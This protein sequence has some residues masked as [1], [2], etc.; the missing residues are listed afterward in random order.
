M[1]AHTRMCTSARACV[2]TC[3]CCSR[4]PT[5]NGALAQQSSHHPETRHISWTHFLAPSQDRGARARS[6]GTPPPAR[7]LGRHQS[8]L[9]SHP[10]PTRSPPRP[11][12]STPRPTRGAPR[13]Q[14]CLA[15]C[16]AQCTVAYALSTLSALICPA[17]LHTCIPA[18]SVCVCVCVCYR[19]AALR[20][21][22]ADGSQLRTTQVYH[23]GDRTLTEPATSS[24]QAR[25]HAPLRSL[26]Y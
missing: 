25:L 17:Y 22:A 4:A 19:Q 21:C 8:R 23:R 26:T 11:T 18:L 5:R 13:P 16:L 24:R 20:L 9:V 2:C 6:K 14:P 3:M 15:Q 1:E 10:L 12:R 7:G